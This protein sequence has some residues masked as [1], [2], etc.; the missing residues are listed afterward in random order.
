MSRFLPAEHAKG[1]ESTVG[2]YE[3]VHGRPASFDGPDGCA[4]S[5]ACL[6][7]ALDAAGVARAVAEAEAGAGNASGRGDAAF[8]AYF[9]FLRWR[10]I[11]EEGVDGHIESDFLEFAATGDDALLRL[12]AWPV[13]RAQAVLRDLAAAK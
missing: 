11:G 13:A 3:A 7:D 5:V 6:V 4:Y 8:G 1:D 12:G 10:R 9:L 2:G